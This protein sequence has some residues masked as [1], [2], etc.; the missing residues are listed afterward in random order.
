[1][2]VEPDFVFVLLWHFPLILK[3]NSRIIFDKDLLLCGDTH[4]GRW[5]EQLLVVADLQSWFVAVAN[6]IHFLD[7]RRVVV[8]NEM[9][10]KI[11][12]PW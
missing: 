3:R 12:V 6:Q 9:C 11:V 2:W 7:V 5:E 8:V 10:A 4:I 1:M